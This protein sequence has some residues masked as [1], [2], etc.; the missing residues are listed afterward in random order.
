MAQLLKGGVKSRFC[1]TNSIITTSLLYTTFT[2][3]KQR[4]AF[5]VTRLAFYSVW[6]TAWIVFIPLRI[7]RFQH[8]VVPGL[9]LYW[10]IL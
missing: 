10:I 6:G 2:H 8:V 5:T 9:R 7:K 4:T 3:E 1:G